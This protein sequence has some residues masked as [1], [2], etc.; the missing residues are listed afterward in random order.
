LI[1]QNINTTKTKNNQIIEG[2]IEFKTH[3]IK[4]S[5]ILTLTGW[6][7][8]G[9]SKSG[10]YSG[11]AYKHIKETI[12]N[13]WKKQEWMDIRW[14]PKHPEH[15]KFLN[16]EQAQAEKPEGWIEKPTF[17]Y[18]DKT[19]D[20]K[21]NAPLV[22]YLLKRLKDYTKVE[23]ENIVKMNSMH[24]IRIYELLRCELFNA[25]L[26]KNNGIYTANVKSLKDIL[27]V[28]DYGNYDF[29]R[30]IIE[31]AIKEI[32]ELT[33]LNVEV[34]EYPKSG[35][36]I[37]EIKFKIQKKQKQKSQPSKEN[38]TATQKDEPQKQETEETANERTCV[39]DGEECNDPFCGL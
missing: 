35:R 38:N 9:K 17:Y 15:K 26:P 32:N 34:L 18:Y 7:D 1:A 39:C 22:P 25:Q 30:K 31:P 36:K 10:S 29:K 3:L 2:D 13:L 24:S 20:L 27:K 16:G 12:L 37:V 6:E 21:L 8:T 5:E 4:F 23:I 14:D 28:E 11:E 19:V 33:D